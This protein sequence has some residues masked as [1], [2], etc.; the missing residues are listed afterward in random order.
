MT[1]LSDSEYMVQAG[2]FSEQQRLAEQ[3]GGPPVTN[4]CDKGMRDEFSA[5]SFGGQRMLTPS[6][7]RSVALWANPVDAI[8][9]DAVASNRS[10][11]EQMVQRMCDGLFTR[12]FLN[13]DDFGL[14]HIHWLNTASR[15]NMLYR[16]LSMKTLRRWQST[17]WEAA[18]RQQFDLRQNEINSD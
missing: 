3:D 7:K 14:L 16:P 18:V 6:L 11:N 8:I 2:I 12:E 17:D 9:T 5:Q 4:M 1:P 15:L 13:N 10:Q